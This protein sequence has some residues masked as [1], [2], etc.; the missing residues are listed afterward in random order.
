MD[1]IS[2]AEHTNAFTPADLSLAQIAVGS[3][4]Q[5][6]EAYPKPGL[7]SRIDSG[8]HADMDYDVM[9]RSSRVLLHPFAR[10]AAAGRNAGS[11]KSIIVPLGLEAENEMLLATGGVNTHRGAIFSLGLILAALALVESRSTSK[12]PEQVRA[13]LLE[14]WGEALQAHANS[15]NYG[16]SHGSKVRRATG[17]GGARIE[18]ARGFPC[19]FEIG[20]PSYYE[21]L[22][23]GLDLNASRIQTLFILM[24]AV[25][26][27]NVI[28]RGGLEAA[29]FVRRTAGQFLMDG[30]CGRDDWFDRAEELHRTFIQHNLSP[31]GSADLL[32][33]TL[34]VASSCD[35]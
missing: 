26:D 15:G 17:S 7:V 13:K 25:D 11:F 23:S 31:G 4:L 32:S 14:T 24:E 20:V 1:V 29:D 22:A 33:G 35:M 28:F 30:G 3:L 6:L 21:A 18:A 8:A 5:E 16:N 12:T 19:I 2:V 34:L 10:I 27:S 9:N